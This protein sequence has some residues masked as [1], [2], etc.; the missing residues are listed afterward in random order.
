MQLNI[1]IL[2]HSIPSYACA[3]GDQKEVVLT[4]GFGNRREVSV[5]STRVV[6]FVRNLA[7]LNTGR[8]YHACASY[9]DGEKNVRKKMSKTLKYTCKLI[10]IIF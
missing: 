10:L 9:N 7:D 8:Q 5:Y 6:P 4:G 1:Q 3:I 2:T